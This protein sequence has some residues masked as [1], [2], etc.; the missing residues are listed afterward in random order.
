MKRKIDLSLILEIRDLLKRLLESHA[1][2]GG[3]AD[4][5][6]AALDLPVA[7]IM[8]VLTT[9]DR[10]FANEGETSRRRGP[11]ASV[12]RTLAMDSTAREARSAATQAA[13]AKARKR[14]GLPM[15]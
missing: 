10:E 11:A 8:R 2:N 14:R 7:T 6:V 1:D 13:F 12:T 3:H 15:S 5:I 9:L 4:S